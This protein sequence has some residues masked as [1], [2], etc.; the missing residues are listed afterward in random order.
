[1]PRK[2]ASEAPKKKQ[3]KKAAPETVPAAKE[4][5]E[6]LS[7]GDESLSVV[8]H[9]DELR[10]RLL[11]VLIT[12]CVTT[13]IPF[14]AAGGKILT[15]LTWPFYKS[16]L[17]NQTLNVFNLT[18]GFML[19]LKASLIVGLLAAL[20]VIVY[21]IW[22]Y[23]RPAID[24]E[25]RGFFRYVLF[26]AILFFYTGTG[27]TFFFF[28][29]F[30]IRVLAEFTPANMTTMFNASTYLHFMMFFCASMGGVFEMPLVIMILT[31]LGIVTPAFLTAKR[32]YA[33]VAIWICAAMITPSTDIL[34]QSLV[35]IPLMLLYE[36]SVL[37]SKIMV[38]RAK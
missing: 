9:L 35:A 1:M 26:F 4:D 23:I 14:F 24:K 25:K 16:G 3:K 7:R 30:T 8:G 31:K 27:L 38:I 33:I 10:S 2:A 18:E 37:I 36:V 34:T 12:V 29:P 6:A 5:I 15:A 22:A 32:K 21:Q 13:V 17:A 19:Q 11:V 28:M 20:P